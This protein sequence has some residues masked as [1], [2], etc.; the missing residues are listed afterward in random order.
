M[1]MPFTID[2]F[3]QLFRDYNTSIFPFQFIFYALAFAVIYLVIKPSRLSS[4]LIGSILGF[5]WLWMGIVCHII[6]FAVI[7][8]AALLFGSLFIL[9]G[10]LILYFTLFK[11]TLTFKFKPDIYG[12][13]GM[14]MIVFA[15]LIY[16]LLGY[17]F[18]HIYPSS[19]AFGV[20]CPTTIFTFGIFLMSVN[21][22]PLTVLV[23]PFLWSLLGF[24]AALQLG[25]TEDTGLVVAGLVAVIMLLV[26]NRQL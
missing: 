20:P 15:L 5:F 2:Q 26:R 18:G 10:L 13:T 8:K 12:I 23:I 19:P 9:E 7:N 11:K 21:R 6:F 16:P 4:L 22:I 3:L 24:S 1:N 25:I 17:L 14:I